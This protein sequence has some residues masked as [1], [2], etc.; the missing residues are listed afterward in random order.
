M[1][2]KLTH[3]ERIEKVLSY[4]K[5]DRIPISFWRH[6]PVDDQSPE[7]LARATLDFQNKFDFDFVKVTP[8]SSFCLKDWGARDD[9]RGNPEGTRDYLEPIICNVGDFDKLTLKN[10]SKGYMG[11]QLEC[12]KILRHKLSKDTPIIQT[13]FN[14]LAQMK[15]LVG[16]NKLQYY[17]RV[18][19]DAALKA[20]NV[21]T[22]TTIDFI[23]RCSR[24]EIDGIF[25]AIQSA[26]YDILSEIE[27][28]EF[29]K[30]FD[31]QILSTFNVFWFNV[32]HLHGNNVMFD[33]VRD[34]PCQV[35]NWHDRETYPKLEEALNQTRMILCGGLNRI[36]SM[37][38]GNEKVI[39]REINDAVGQTYG[40]QLI[41]S[42]GCVLPITTPEC[43]IISARSIIEKIGIP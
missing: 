35:I 19:P 25:Y 22:E 3:R 11:K 10:P 29:G 14:P 43:N 42:T 17:L 9:W 8:S 41:I 34:Y 13:I 31:L 7:G 18:Y 27:Y 1:N 26:S 20:L 2:N 38:Q 37:L 40:K 36:N 16:K 4:E 30:F 6:F 32:L 12:L 21:I 33:I 5:P 39:S 23:D 24:C 15:N 28:I